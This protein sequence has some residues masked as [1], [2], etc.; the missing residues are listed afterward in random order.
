M[1]MLLLPS[2]L[3]ST[4]ASFEKEVMFFL[5]FDLITSLASAAYFG[6]GFLHFSLL[7]TD[8]LKTVAKY[9]TGISIFLR[10]YLKTW[11][12]CKMRC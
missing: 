7:F 4:P 12:N 11:D 2:S 9:I 3:A 10:V 6:S 1:I 8:T 5:L